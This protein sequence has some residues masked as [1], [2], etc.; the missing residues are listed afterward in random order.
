MKQKTES[1]KGENEQ[2]SLKVGAALLPVFFLV[3]WWFQLDLKKKKALNCS[4]IVKAQLQGYKKHKS[5]CISLIAQKFREFLP[6]QYLYQ[7]G[8]WQHLILNRSI[9][10]LHSV[11]WSLDFSF[12]TCWFLQNYSSLKIN[13]CYSL[14]YEIWMF[15]VL[16]T[17][18]IL[19]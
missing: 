15:P 8:T 18:V 10:C 4:E 19:H 16:K 14:K 11:F 5:L 12:C 6:F 17:V 3:Y 1:R 9:S 2:I 7:V 13:L